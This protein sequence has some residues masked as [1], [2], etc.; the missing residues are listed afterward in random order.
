MHLIDKFCNH[1]INN[2]FGF[3]GRCSDVKEP[4]YFIQN[5]EQKVVSFKA[6]M[7]LITSVLLLVCLFTSVSEMKGD[8]INTISGSAVSI[9]TNTLQLV[10]LLEEWRP[11]C[12]RHVTM[13]SRIARL[14][15]IF[16]TGEVT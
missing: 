7:T 1:E 14:M 3:H 6:W 11:S 16:L 15:C 9:V 4:F 5:E 8:S 2:T 13:A 12:L 10:L